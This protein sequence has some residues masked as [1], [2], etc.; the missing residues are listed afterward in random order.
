M[1]L[2][3][4]FENSGNWLFRR[5]SFLPLLLFALVMAGLLGVSGRSGQGPRNTAWHLG[6]LLL[7]LAGLV[8]RAWTVGHVPP[9]TS[10][11]NTRE[12][13]ADVLNTT[14]VYSMVRHPLY[15]G[16]YLMWLSVALVPRTLWLPIVVSLVFWLYHER[17]M[18]AE[19]QFLKRRFGPQ[20]VEWAVRTPAFL[21]SF[22]GW[23]PASLPFSLRI[24]LRREHSGLLGLVAAITA[25]VTAESWLATGRLSLDPLWGALLAS[26]VVVYLLL[27]LLKKKTRALHVAR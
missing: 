16:N 22:S 17:I 15:L 14:G 1:T 24:A 19:E 8:F 11:R 6:C 18:F 27:Y 21:P 3:D 9:R 10:G 12:Q 26:A 13:I 20:F 23:V 7:G 4:H 25:V 5:R 2:E